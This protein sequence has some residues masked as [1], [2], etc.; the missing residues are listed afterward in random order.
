M[1][2]TDKEARFLIN[3]LYETLFWSDDPLHETP[4]NAYGIFSKL[5]EAFP[6]QADSVREEKE[7]ERLQHIEAHRQQ[8]NNK[9][10]EN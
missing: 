10:E 4:M 8:M 7:M 9:G 5:V 1:K 6:E 3:E 2:L